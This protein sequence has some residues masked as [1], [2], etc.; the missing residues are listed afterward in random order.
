MNGFLKKECPKTTQHEV[1]TKINCPVCGTAFTRKDNLKAHQKACL[2][3]IS[4][5]AMRRH[6]NGIL[7]IVALAV[8]KK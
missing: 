5:K 6:H 1:P 3:E 7:R 2:T 8:R 4:K